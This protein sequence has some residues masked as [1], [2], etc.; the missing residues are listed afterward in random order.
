[1][2]SANETSESLSMKK[3]NNKEEEKEEGGRE[4]RRKGR[5]EGRRKEG[6]GGR[7][8]EKPR[9]TVCVFIC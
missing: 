7:K 1:M 8:E 2:S 9:E 6:R 3:F 4:G 5:K